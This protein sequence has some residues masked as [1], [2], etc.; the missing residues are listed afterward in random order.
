MD[1]LKKKL[2][3]K[4]DLLITFLNGLVIIFSIFVLN[5]LIARLY[6]LEFLGEF[7]YVKRVGNSILGIILVGMN[8][9]LPFF[10]AKGDK[11]VANS[12][13]FIFITITLPLS[14]LSI[15]VFSVLSA[16]QFHN[17]HFFAYTIFFIGIATQ[18][19]T[20]GLY[21]GHMNMVGANAFQLITTS[22]IPITIFVIIDDLYF[23][24]KLIGL[25]TI[26]IS[27]I[28]YFYRSELHFNFTDSLRQSYKLIKYGFYR[29]P[30]FIAQFL[31]L[32][33]LPVLLS[34]DISLINMA[35]INSGISLV[36]V[37][38][39]IITPLGM[40][41]LPRVSNALSRNVLPQ[42][43]ENISLLV[44]AVHIGAWLAGFSIY[45]FADYILQ[46]WLGTVTQNG[47]WIIRGLIIALPFYAVMG[48]LRSPIDALSVK[49]YNS[50]IYVIS[51]V[52]M[53][54]MFTIL[55][56]SGL[57]VLNSGIAAFIIGHFSTMILSIFVSR[58]FLGL[59]ISYS[60]IFM[61][62]ISV[63]LILYLLNLL[64][65]T[66]VDNNTIRFSLYII[67]LLSSS[68]IFYFKS[69]SIW[70]VDL[71]SKISFQK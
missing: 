6:G 68:I 2:D 5:A 18:F 26:L 44:K 55:K 28:S 45:I 31:L 47:I 42:I 53:I 56:L 32:A 46:I 71:R 58:K 17:E 22:I 8:V 1:F 37:S 23:A 21:R 61:T 40:I 51:A 39:I 35:F 60:W 63:I 10:L 52:N 48:V 15:F 64:L 49:S 69:N 50:L 9:G 54:I 41:L 62:S 12:A 25:I 33:G 43:E 36:R 59:R 13:I 66:F 57:N 3:A 70:I 30:S 29:Y 14:I 7:T 11:N 38:L 27:I 65:E 4:S 19:L 24:L 16:N 67:I 34:N 20:Y